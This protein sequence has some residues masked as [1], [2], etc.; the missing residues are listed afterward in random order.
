MYCRYGRENSQRH[1][2]ES[3]AE[4]KSRLNMASRLD[5]AKREAE[6][7]GRQLERGGRR[8]TERGRQRQHS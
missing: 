4:K 8:E 2:E 6:A 3:R 7:L 1:L 5:M